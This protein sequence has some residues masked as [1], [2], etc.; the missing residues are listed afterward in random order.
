MPHDFDPDPVRRSIEL[1]LGEVDRGTW[2]GRYANYDDEHISLEFALTGDSCSEDQAPLAFTLGPLEGQN[3]VEALETRMVYHLDRLRIATDGEP[4]PLMVS[5]V[6]DQPWKIAPGY[7]RDLFLGR[8]S[9]LAVLENGAMEQVFPAQAS[10]SIFR[11]PLYRHV[12]GVWMSERI[13]QNP[14]ALNHQAYINPWSKFT[15]QAHTLPGPVLTLDRWEAE[16]AVMH[17]SSAS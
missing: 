14:L 3:F 1:W 8:P 6:T 16:Q 11:D 9:R 10:A 5:C 12:C 7:L 4:R 13:S 15:M 17:W 2:E